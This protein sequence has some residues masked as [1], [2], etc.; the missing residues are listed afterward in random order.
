MR[1]QLIKLRAAAK[2]IESATTDINTFRIFEV[3][4]A[5]HGLNISTVWLYMQDVAIEA[6]KASAEIPLGGGRGKVKQSD[7]NF[8]AM[9]VCASVIYEAWEFVRQ[10]PPG[11]ASGTVQD[12]AE[13]FW[14]ATGGSGPPKAELNERWKN[15]L[16]KARDTDGEWRRRTHACLEDMRRREEHASAFPLTNHDPIWWYG[17]KILPEV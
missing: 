16:A 5:K 15:H 7:D 9:E 6:G 2:V 13:Y 3:L 17:I 10:N 8:S 14:R 11:I 4:V 12:A 1:K